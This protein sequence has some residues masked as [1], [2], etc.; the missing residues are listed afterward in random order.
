LADERPPMISPTFPFVTSEKLCDGSN[1][2]TKGINS[3]K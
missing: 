2:Y 3:A 1:L